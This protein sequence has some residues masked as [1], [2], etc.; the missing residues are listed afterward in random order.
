MTP[1]AVNTEG[2]TADEADTEALR[3][4]F[5]RDDSQLTPAE[6]ETT[7]RFAR[8]QDRVEF[9][10][11]EAGL[12]RRLIAHPASVVDGA[13]V[14]DEG[15]RPTRAP[16]DVEPDDQVVGVLGSLPIGAL[17]IKTDTRENDQHAAVVSPRVFDGGGRGE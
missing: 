8:D 7:F 14:E 3:A 12:G 17:S 1:D 4:A 5:D 16:E 6:K 9:Y 13:V 11:A 15:A 10:T 2:G